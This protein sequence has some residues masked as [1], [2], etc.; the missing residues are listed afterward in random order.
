HPEFL[1]VARNLAHSFIHQRSPG[2]ART[3]WAGL[4]AVRA[5]AFA[6]V[7]G[8][9]ERFTRPTVEDIDLGYRLRNAGFRILLE[10]PIQGKHLKRWTFRSSVVSDIRDRGIPWTQLLARYEMHDDLNVTLEYRA[11]VIVAALMVICTLASIRWP[12]LL[13]PAMA[14]IVALWLL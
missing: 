1:S 8:F 14:A 2:E 9:D 3:F 7:R 5:S 11:C 4:G 12:L 6:T 10:P 13:L